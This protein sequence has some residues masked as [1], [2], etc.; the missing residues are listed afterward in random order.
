MIV[1]AR[2]RTLWSLGRQLLPEMM[3]NFDAFLTVLRA[4]REK[5]LAPSFEAR[6]L[7]TLYTQVSPT[8]FSRDLLQGASP[9][10]LALRMEGVYWCDWLDPQRIADSLALLGRRP[11]FEF[12]GNTGSRGLSSGA[13]GRG[14]DLAATHI[15]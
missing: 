9:H 3:A 14:H 12:G 5:R 2:A 10:S 7:E 11:P 13:A 1:A 4:I 6:A 8:D 15:R